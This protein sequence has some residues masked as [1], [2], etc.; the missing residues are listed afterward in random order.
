MLPPPEEIEESLWRDLLDP[1]FP[2]CIDPAGGY[3][4]QFGPAFEPMGDG[5]RNLVFQ[6]RMIWVC[7]SVASIRPKFADYARHGVRFLKERMDGGLT[8]SLDAEGEPRTA[9]RHAYGIAFAIYGLAAAARHLGDPEALAMAVRA[10]DYLAAAHA[11]PKNGGYFEVSDTEGRAKLSG[12]GVDA[13]GTPYGQKSQNT[14]LHL[15]EA[16][17]ELYRAHPDPSVAANLQRM[18]QIFTG[19]L[20][21][22]SGHLHLFAQPDWTPASTDISYGHDIEAAHLILDAAD[23]LG[24]QDVR[25]DHCTRAL[26]DH[27]L[28]HGWDKE[29]GGIF[30]SGTAEGPIRGSK[31]WWAQAESLLGFTTLWSR[32]GDPRY[33]QAL[34]KQWA[35]IRDHQIDP[36]CGWHEEVERDGTPRLGLKG[37]GW[38]AAYHDGRALLFTARILRANDCRQW[39]TM[40][41]G[42]PDSEPS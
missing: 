24:V 15:V 3:R 12:D 5:V 13:I 22:P 23:A 27:T 34:A 16:F 35:F 18:L 29:F 11:D 20:F 4:Q 19:E 41:H 2:A 25:I 21:D 17:S 6:S 1:W 38:K 7:A 42:G 8:W 39:P 40:A 28:A 37:H 26:A 33:E 32:T 31:N 14:H 36:G 10:H 9:E 30:Y